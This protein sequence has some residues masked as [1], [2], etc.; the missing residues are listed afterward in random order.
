ML[1]ALILIFVGYLLYKAWKLKRRVDDVRNQF[2][3]QMEEA[4]RQFA[5]AQGT[6]PPQQPQQRKKYRKDRG[7][8]VDFEELQPEVAAE[9]KA[10]K[11][12]EEETKEKAK[13]EKERAKEDLIT[14]AEFE[15]IN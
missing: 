13:A 14:D 12:A 4:Q 9:E 7:E 5:G 8:Y 10:A 15:E 3:Q 2:R 1:T 6:T 11:E